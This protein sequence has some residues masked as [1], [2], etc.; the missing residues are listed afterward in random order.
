MKH[1]DEELISKGDSLNVLS[2]HQ[3]WITVTPK[4]KNRTRPLEMEKTE[5][6]D[7]PSKSTPYWMISKHQ[8][9]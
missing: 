1:V 3:G 8:C 9:I 6:M 2:G 7:Q 4:T 5:R